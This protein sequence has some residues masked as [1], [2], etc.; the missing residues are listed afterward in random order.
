[1]CVLCVCGI[2]R[3]RCCQ[4]LI[5]CSFVL[6]SVLRSMPVQD[7]TCDLS[8]P[9]PHEGSSAPAMFELMLA[10]SAQNTNGLSV[11]CL[12]G[13]DRVPLSVHF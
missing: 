1:M 13:A 3:E 8:D 12:L 10:C 6:V 5:C 4:T 11:G 9:M 2:F 7:D